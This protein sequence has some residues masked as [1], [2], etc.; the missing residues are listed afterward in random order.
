L[1]RKI[2]V[3]VVV[4]IARETIGIILIVCAIVLLVIAISLSKEILENIAD[5]RFALDNFHILLSCLKQ[6]LL[7]QAMTSSTAAWLLFIII[8]EVS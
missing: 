1:Q 6:S 3:I 2:I 4:V 5:F 7:Q 8:L